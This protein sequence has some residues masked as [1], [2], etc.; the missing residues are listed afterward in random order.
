MCN[1]QKPDTGEGGPAHERT[2]SSW[3]RQREAY[4]ASLVHFAHRWYRSNG[5]DG[6]G[7]GDDNGDGDGDD[8]DGVRV[9]KGGD[10][11]LPPID[12]LPSPPPARRNFS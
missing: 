10:D 6:G 9:R 7:H 4:L 5:G 12:L 2:S 1:P 11:P 8:G 3:E